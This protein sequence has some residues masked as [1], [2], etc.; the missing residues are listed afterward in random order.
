MA[1]K[2][3]KFLTA[4]S[5]AV[6]FLSI[7]LFL[8]SLFTSLP[9][10]EEDSVIDPWSVPVSEHFRC[11]PFRGRLW[12]FT[13][14]YPYQGSILTL[15]DGNRVNWGGEWTTEITEWEWVSGS[16]GISQQSFI[17]QAGQNRGKAR[18]GDF[19]GI[20]YRHFEWWNTDEPWTTLRVSLFYLIGLSAILPLFWIRSKV[21]A[22][23][24]ARN[25]NAS[26]Q[27]E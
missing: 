18:Y 13:G 1:R 10:L 27:R 2:I 22:L 14:D 12:I 17:D 11:I 15:K 16:N 26:D 21:C 25:Q 7:A 4:C 24:L 9:E 5:A 20:Y 19:P 6:L 8:I 23:R 3:F